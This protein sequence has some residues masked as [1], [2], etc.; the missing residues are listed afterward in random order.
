MSPAFWFFVAM[1]FGILMFFLGVVS[2]VSSLKL[3]SLLR[4][5]RITSLVLLIGGAVLLYWA[6]DANK[7]RLATVS[8]F[9][10]Q[11]IL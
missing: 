6:M 1:F 2:L 11:T 10:A 3:G 8:A 4:A 7:Q 9:T 5:H